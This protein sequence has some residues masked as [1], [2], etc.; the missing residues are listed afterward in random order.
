M[1]LTKNSSTPLQPVIHV[2]IFIAC[3]S[4]VVYQCYECLKKYN[5]HPQ[6][7]SLTT[8]PARTTLFPVMTICPTKADIDA[9]AYLNQT[10]LQH[11]GIE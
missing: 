11:C 8:E 3:F 2:M 1:T 5:G 9:K 6:G 4:F 10:Y 7:T